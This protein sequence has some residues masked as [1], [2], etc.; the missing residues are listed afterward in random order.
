MRGI[1]VDGGL[2]DPQLP[3]VTLADRV[4]FGRRSGSCPP[5]G[6]VR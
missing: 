4:S 5:R 2:V 3:V 1:L 6:D